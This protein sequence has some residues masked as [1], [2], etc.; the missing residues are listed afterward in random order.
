M[1]WQAETSCGNEAAKIRHLIVPYTRGHGLDLGCGPFKAWPHFIGVDNFDEWKG[2]DWRPDIASDCTDLSLIADQSCDFVFSSHLLEHLDNTD[3]ALREWWRVIKQDGH[4]VLYLPHKEFYPNIGEPGSNPDH[5]HDF[6]PADI[7]EAMSEIGGWD[8]VVNEERGERDEYSFLQIYQKIGGSK[9]RHSWQSKALSSG[10]ERCL[11]IRY[12]AFGD[13]IMASSVLP[14][15][16]EQGYHIVYNTTPRGQDIVKHDPHIDEFWIQD[17]DQVPNQDLGDYWQA[18]GREFDRV[19]NLSES[20]EGQLLALPGRRDHALPKEARHAVMNVNYLE[21]QHAIA[22]VPAPY[23]PRFYATGKEDGDAREDMASIRGRPAILW[24]LAGSSVHKVW[25]FVGDVV[26]KF[27]SDTDAT[28]IF[29]GGPECQLLEMGITQQ[30]LER[31]MGVPYADSDQMKLSEMLIQ[32]KEYFGR[33][34]LVCR[35]GSWSIRETMARL[36]YVDM[37]VGPETGVLNAACLLDVPKVVML[38]HSSRENLTKHWRN[39]VAIMPSGVSCYPCH[40]MHYDR[41]F[42]P[43]DE[44]TGASVCA[45]WIKPQMVVTAIQRAME[46]VEQQKRIAAAE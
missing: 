21:F 13:Q 6:L 10:K 15:L 8:L 26:A 45:A 11:V 9:K 40:R 32:L 17:T 3:A 30:I 7:I 29:V 41:K 33:N 46:L 28:F 23:C 38:S 2:L 18:L 14:G 31:F 5:R 44:A 1:T 37:V 4:L 42:C 20:V 27:L 43:E 35:S 36:P 24:A 16:K 19:I 22:G 34:R 12:G 25:P 39:T